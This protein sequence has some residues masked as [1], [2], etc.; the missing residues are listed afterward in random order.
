MIQLQEI[1]L[2]LTA[3]GKLRRWQADIDKIASYEDRVAEADKKFKSRNTTRNTT[4]KSV[5]QALTQM[6]SGAR[7]CC[8]CEDSAADEVN[9]SNPRT[10][11]R[12]FALRGTTTSMLAVHATDR[13][14]TNLPCSPLL[15]G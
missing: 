14:I 13:R 3:R 9:T 10:S 5:R 8:Y 6:C 1:Q 7:R 15:R 4:F 11:T 2:P 12:K